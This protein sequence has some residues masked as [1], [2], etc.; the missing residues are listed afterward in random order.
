MK[1]RL[2]ATPVFKNGKNRME[3]RKSP[4]V[5]LLIGSVATSAYLALHEPASVSAPPEKARSKAWNFVHD[6]SIQKYVSPEIGFTDP[7]YV[8]KKLVELKPGKGLRTKPRT[9]LRKEAEEALR[10]LS[11]NYFSQF[12][13]ELPVVSGYRSYGHQERIGKGSPR[14]LESGFCSKPGHS[15]HQSGL[16]VDFFEAGNV[17]AFRTVPEMRARFDWL[18]KNAPVYG[19]TNS[20]RKGK[21]TDGYREEPWH[22]RYV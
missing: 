1:H 16:A 5:L 11:N 15:E 14:C 18:T 20:Y 8:P 2:P 4:S 7:Q 19:F 3:V 6:D 13:T 17:E 12:G 10:K 22:W 21:E 9:F